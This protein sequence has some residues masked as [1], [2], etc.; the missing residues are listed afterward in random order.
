MVGGCPNTHNG[1]PVY[2]LPSVIARVNHG[3]Q[4]HAHENIVVLKVCAAKQQ[5]GTPLRAVVVWLEICGRATS[6]AESRPVHSLAVSTMTDLAVP[7]LET[8]TLPY[9]PTSVGEVYM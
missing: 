2:Y 9:S 8:L 4:A 3:P 7:E 6:L 5:H 1:V